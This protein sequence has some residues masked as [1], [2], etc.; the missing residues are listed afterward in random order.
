MADDG[1]VGSGGRV[2]GEGVGDMRG[3]LKDDVREFKGLSLG[4]QALCVLTFILGYLSPL[5]GIVLAVVMRLRGKA[6]IWILVPLLGAVVALV[7]YVAIYFAGV[8]G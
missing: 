8:L 3:R 2:H 4:W 6:R 1:I 5:V 7:F